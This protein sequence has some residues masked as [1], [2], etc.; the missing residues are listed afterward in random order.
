MPDLDFYRALPKI[1]LHR[2]LEG[3]LRLAT[4]VEVASAYDLD[5]PAR[6]AASLGPL[7]QIQPG[8]PPTH[9]NFLSK[10]GVLR[11]FFCAP[12]VIRRFTREAIEDAAADN[13]RYLELR[14]TPV[15]LS[16]VQGYTLADVMAWVLETAQETAA[17]TGVRTRL[18][19]SAN[20]HESPDLAAQVGTL[21]AACLDQGLVALDLGG[22]EANFPAEPF[23]EIFHDARRAGLG[24]TLHAGEWSGAE[25]VA[26][27]I[28]Q[29]GVDRI[30]HGVR[31]M[32]DMDVARLARD[33]GVVFEVCPT[34]NYQSGVIAHLSAHSLPAML[35]VGLDV[36]INTDDPGISALTLSDEYRLACEV[37]GLSLRQLRG[38]VLAAAQAAF[39]PDTERSALIAQIEADFPL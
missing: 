14:F 23:A 29:I 9:Q 27:A 5:I 1:D 13:V 2:H 39:L 16:R 4:L 21:A 26:I 34:S 38:C 7:V 24:I 11:H 35:A 25:N 37:L 15:A 8:D 17:E 18:I 10:F 33:R 20:R 19:A 31:V 22:D 3:S 28:E 6:D 36:T 32:E 30:G 12:E